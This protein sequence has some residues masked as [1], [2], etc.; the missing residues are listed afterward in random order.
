MSL[1]QLVVLRL[2][3]KRLR[4]VLGEGSGGFRIPLTVVAK[5]TMPSTG[6][7]VA[8]AGGA[9]RAEMAHVGEATVVGWAPAEKATR[10][11]GAI[12]TREVKDYEGGSKFFAT[13]VFVAPPGP[14]VPLV[15]TQPT[16]VLS[17]S[18]I[19]STLAAVPALSAL[20]ASIDANVPLTAIASTSPEPPPSTWRNLFASN[21]DTTRCPKLT[22]YSAFTETRGCNLVDDDF[23]TKCDY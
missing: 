16:S 4:Q 20:E 14:F 11:G 22:Y 19:D 23:D 10:T 5:G 2:D 21:R 8:H 12:T 3:A 9:T 6:A 17:L 1:G 7:D 13:L 18:Y 15:V